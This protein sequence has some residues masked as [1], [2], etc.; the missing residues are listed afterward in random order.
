MRSLP[1]LLVIAIVASACQPTSITISL[2][3]PTPT[4]TWTP[5]PTVDAAATAAVQA[6]ATTTAQAQATTNARATVDAQAT[7]NAQANTTATAAAQAT[8]TAKANA[9]ETARIQATA[10]AQAAATATT[11]AL[12][13]AINAI[14]D[15]APAKPYVMK[16]ETVTGKPSPYVTT[17]YPELNMLN[18]VAEVQF[19]NPADPTIHPWDFGFFFRGSRQ[20]E[21]RLVI[22]SD[23]VWYLLLVDTNLPDAVDGKIITQ[24][25]VLNLNVATDGSNTYRLVVKDKLGFLFV[26]NQYTAAMD[27]S[28]RLASGSFYIGTGMNKGANFPGL[29]LHFKN[30]NVKWLN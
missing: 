24:G 13:A 1:V 11:Q 9:T 8:A 20:D 14:A 2:G 28:A 29:Q 12:V 25:T 3:Q 7:A 23:K 16:E 17:F 5:T 6:A 22:R 15:A 26:N 27:V 4:S 19:F 30:L 21:Y 18:F 10:A